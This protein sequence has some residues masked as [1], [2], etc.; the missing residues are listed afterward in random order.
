MAI[1]SWR[2]LELV[3]MPWFT[4]LFFFAGIG[5]LAALVAWGL[6]RGAA[7]AFLLTGVS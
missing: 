6:G 3:V 1:A 4:I 5:P 2:E 7:G